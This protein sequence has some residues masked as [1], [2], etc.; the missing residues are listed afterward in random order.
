MTTGLLPQHRRK[1]TE[2]FK[3]TTMTEKQSEKKLAWSEFT[4]LYAQK[5]NLTFS[6]ALV[7]AGEAWRSYNTSFNER[8][9]NYKP[10]TT[11]KKRIVKKRTSPVSESPKGAITKQGV[12]KKG[13]KREKLG[14]VSPLRSDRKEETPETED[15]DGEYDY[16]KKETVIKRMKKK[17]PP[18]S[19]K[20]SETDQ[21]SLSTKPPPKKKR[22]RTVSLQSLNPA[23]IAGFDNHP[24]KPR[25]G[26]AKSKE[27]T[28]NEMVGESP[29]EGEEEMM[30]EEEEGEV[31]EE[32]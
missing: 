25:G 20:S 26:E 32:E 22:K 12:G 11:P 15:S 13:K 10:T 24:P 2:T 29:D 18:S 28:E 4:K 19:N 30:E 6:Q 27:E 5:Y 14:D 3:N 16:V 8:N 21:P 9:P 31:G 7:H 23:V 1:P 17:Q